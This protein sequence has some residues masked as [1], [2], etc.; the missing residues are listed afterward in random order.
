MSRLIRR[1]LGAT[2]VGS[3]ALALAACSAVG[4]LGANAS[5]HASHAQ[6]A[7]GARLVQANCASCH[8]VGQAGDSPN[9]EA[10]PFRTLS[11]NYPIDDLEEA[12]AE[13]AIVGHSNMPEF[14][15]TP[16][17]IDA[18]TAYLKSIQEPAN[19]RIH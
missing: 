14:R 9:P 4:H 11:A 3:I 1:A 16:A 6:I 15:F 2:L 13:G 10:R 18:L 19:N 17:Q 12:F 8:A 5:P 7:A